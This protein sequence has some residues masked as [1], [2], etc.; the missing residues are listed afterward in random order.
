MEEDARVGPVSDRDATRSAH[1]S[2]PFTVLFPQIPVLPRPLACQARLSRVRFT[3][4]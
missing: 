2:P 1:V 3:A 4:C